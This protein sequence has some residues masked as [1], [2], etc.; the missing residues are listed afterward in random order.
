[1]NETCAV[2][3]RADILRDSGSDDPYSL[4]RRYP[5]R[6]SKAETIMYAIVDI[7]DKQ[8]KVQEGEYVYVPHHA[9]AEIDDTLTLDQ[10]LLISDGEGDVTL[11]TPTVDGASI[12][13]R[14]IDQVKGDK[15]IVFKKKRR[16]RY[17]VKKG[18][19][20]QYT[21]IQI[22]ALDANG[23]KK[24]ASKKKS[25]KTTAKAEDAEAEAA[26]TASDDGDA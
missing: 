26:D 2:L 21:K 9:D 20:Q 12:T 16:K 10:V 5:T 24:A 4:S 22:E 6:R 11:G 13:A 1:M 15:V 8:F 14:V 18:H 23:K 19:R 17:K 3:W 7:K 25:E